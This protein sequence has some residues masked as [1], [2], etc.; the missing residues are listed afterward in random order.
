[1]TIERE[2]RELEGVTSVS[3]KQ[4]SKTVTVEWKE[5][6]ASWDKIRNLLVEINYPPES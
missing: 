5:P 1:M 6:P 3:A 2:V 4:D